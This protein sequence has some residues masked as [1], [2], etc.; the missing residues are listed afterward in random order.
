MSRQRSKKNWF[1]LLGA[2]VEVMKATEEAD[3]V[4]LQ[5]FK[6]IVAR[7][8]EIGRAPRGL[9]TLGETL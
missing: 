7:Q 9:H 6:V 1:W 2:S 3:L 4:A 8:R 5:V